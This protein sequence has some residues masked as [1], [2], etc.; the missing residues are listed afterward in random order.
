M[1]LEQEPQQYEGHH[2]VT[3]QPLQMKS[4][5]WLRRH[6]RLSQ[7][8]QPSLAV[9][10]AHALWH[11]RTQPHEALSVGLSHQDVL[12]GSPLGVAHALGQLQAGSCDRVNA[13]Q[14]ALFVQGDD[15]CTAGTE[16]L[17]ARAA[18]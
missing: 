5:K 7:A 8:H 3:A 2:V 1:R 12:G 13:V 17:Q 9:A 4:A 16:L 11:M 10:Q 15:C 6:L 18:A 14:P